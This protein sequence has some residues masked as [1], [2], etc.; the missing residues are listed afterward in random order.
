M[1]LILGS[2]WKNSVSDVLE[3]PEGQALNY[4]DHIYFIAGFHVRLCEE[5]T[6]S[7]KKKKKINKKEYKQVHKTIIIIE[8]TLPVICRKS[9]RYSTAKPM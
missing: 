8:E 6:V 9:E 3:V 4:G 1:T 5:K 7:S 2:F